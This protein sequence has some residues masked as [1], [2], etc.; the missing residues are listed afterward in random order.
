MAQST[1]ALQTRKATKPDKPRPDFP[2]FAH[3][4]GK[5]AKVIRNKMHYFG[6]W[7]DPHAAESAY[8]KVADDLHAGRTPRPDANDGLTVGK[9]CNEYLK[10]KRLRMK[11]MQNES[12][13]SH[14]STSLSSSS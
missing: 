3:A 6:R 12:A 9:L 1:G 10:V 14:D 5:W 8:L 7:D 13:A 2:L 4:S 11:K